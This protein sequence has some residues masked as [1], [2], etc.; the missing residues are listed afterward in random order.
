MENRVNDKNLGSWT[1]RERA[2]E[3][4]A[5]LFPVRAMHALLDRDPDGVEAGDLLPFGWHWLYFKPCPK[6]SNVAEDGH[7]KRGSF[8][9]P[10]PLPNRMWA[11]GS[12]SF[13]RPLVVGEKIRKT[14]RIESVEEKEGRTGPL[15]FVAVH[16]RIEDAGG[17]AVEEV[18]N[19]VYLR[20]D[21]SGTAATR[22][23]AAPEA[24]AWE[25][26]FL[27]DDVS[28]FRFSALTFNGHRIHYD[29]RYAQEVE[30]LRDTVVHAPLLAL[31]LLD[32]ASRRAKQLASGT[33]TFEY[34][35]R[36]PLYCGE[37]LHLHGGARS[38]DGTVPL[39]GAS[40][41]GGLVMEARWGI[42][43]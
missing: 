37:E 34:R 20:R 43:P 4:T 21:R 18:Q 29:R 38:A 12:L 1:G 10:V 17:T 39:W 42:V 2:Q 31:L 3:D 32:A 6:R 5:T 9:P 11:G 15:V 24:S 41:D 26:R 22:R 35:A 25:E 36:S 7:E 19:L 13:L 30:G 27:P 8:L 23:P 16:H 14:S 33:L 40:S 28:L